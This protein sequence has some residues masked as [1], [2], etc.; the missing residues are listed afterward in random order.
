MVF[1]IFLIV[2]TFLLGATLRFWGLGNIPDGLSVKEVEFALWGDKII[3]DLLFD[4]FWTRFLFAFIGTIQILL[5]YLAF[6][7]LKR[8]FKLAAV[9]SFL[10]AILPWHIQESR[11]YSEG[12]LIF[13]FF[14]V[15]IILTSKLMLKKPQLFLSLTL[16]FSI[17]MLL[18]SLFQFDKN[19]ELRVNEERLLIKDTQPTVARIFSNK[20][21]ESYR[22]RQDLFFQNLDLGNYFFAG[23]PRERWGVEETQKFYIVFLPIIFLGLLKNNPKLTKTIAASLILAV[24]L[25]VWLDRIPELNIFLIFPVLLLA[26]AGAVFLL[27]LKKILATLALL[28]FFETAVFLTSYFK[29][30][31]ETQFSPRRPVYKQVAE[32]I[33][34]NGEFEEEILI[35]PKLADPEVFVAFY[36]KGQIPGNIKFQGFDTRNETGFDKF[37]VDVLPDDASPSEALNK[38]DGKWPEHLGVLA[39][40]YD[41][42][43][44]QTIVIYR[45]K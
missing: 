37:F 20:A 29:G 16:L 4:P 43:K 26:S 23:H 45:Y 1:K 40:F 41:K 42:P 2:L 31:T 5:L 44:R 7:K 30:Y 34:H 25:P 15:F 11:I 17:V 3:G 38:T 19:L 24:T 8:N 14:L 9:A 28:L 36:Y 27:K 10:L 18:F 6:Y 13:T 35:N 39:E 33:Q 22:T 12:M 32:F 21:I